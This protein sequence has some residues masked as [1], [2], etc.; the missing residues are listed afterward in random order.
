MSFFI[1]RQFINCLGYVARLTVICEQKTAENVKGQRCVIFQ[2]I[3]LELCQGSL[4]K[5]SIN[6]SQSN[7]PPRSGL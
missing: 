2:D 7:R 3:L 6:L 1:S 5:I 4:K